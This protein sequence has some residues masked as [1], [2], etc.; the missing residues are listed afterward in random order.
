MPALPSNFLTKVNSNRY[1]FQKK[2]ID[3][4]TLPK[5]LALEIIASSFLKTEELTR[6]FYSLYNELLYLFNYLSYQVK[7]SPFEIS[8]AKLQDYFKFLYFNPFLWKEKKIN[9]IID[10]WNLLEKI[11]L[12]QNILYLPKVDQKE[13]TTL[14]SD[15]LILKKALHSLGWEELLFTSSQIR[16]T[17][18]SPV[19]ENKEQKKDV[20]LK[21]S[22]S[23]D[24]EKNKEVVLT[25]Q[26]TSAFEKENSNKNQSEAEKG[27]KN[28][29]KEVVERWK[30]KKL[31]ELGIHTRFSTLD[32]ASSPTEYIKSAQEKGYSTL[33]ITDHYNVQAFPEFWQYRKPELKLV[34]GCEM[35]MLED[36]LPP[37]IFN[38][39]SKS[40]EFLSQNIEDLTYCI[41]DLETTGF[42]SEYNEIIEI[43]Y[44]I[45]KKG[46][47]LKEK[48]YLVCPE[49]EIAPEVLRSWYTSIDPKKLKKEKKI[50]QILLEIRQDWKNCV[51]VAH[52][53]R[54]FDFTFVNKVWKEKF[55]EDLPYPVIDTLPLTWIMLPER[56]SYSLEKLSR[57]SGK[58]KIEQ[59]HRALEDSKL[60]TDLFVKLLKSL[61]EKEIKQWKEV[62]SL[63]NHQYFPNR[64]YKVKVLARNQKGLNDLYQLITL[65]H[66]DNLFKVPCVFRSD[67]EKH[68]QSLLIGAAG[69]REGEI[70][71][72]FSAFNSEQVRQNA[73]KFYD[74]IEVNSPSSLRHLWL[75]GRMKEIELKQTSSNIIK[76]AKSLNIPAVVSHNV[77]YCRPEQKIIK[78][79]IVANEGM[80]GSRH[81]LYNEATLDGKEDQ[82]SNL[83]D[84]HLRCR[85]EIVEDWKFLNNAK[86]MEEVIFTNPQKIVEQI[87][88]IVIFDGQL[89]YPDFSESEQK[90]V[91]VYQQKAQEM[92]GNDLPFLVRERINKEW[93]IICEN[94]LSIYWLAY[95]IVQKT[96]QDGFIVGSRGSVGSSFLAYLLN[97]TDLNPL[98]PYYFCQN[99]KYFELYQTNQKVF[100]CYDVD[101]F[102]VC[103]KCKNQLILEGHNLP[104]ETFFGWRGEKTP[105][106]DLNFS[107]EY[108]KT[109]HDYVRGLLGEENVYR[110]GTINKLS[111]QT[112]EIFLREYKKLK[113]SLNPKFNP[114][115]GNGED[116]K[117]WEQLKGI[118]RTT[119]QHPGGLLV[120]PQAI[121]IHDYTP[122]NFPADNKNIEWKTTH[123]EYSFLAKIFLKLDILGHDEPTVL[124]K[125]YELTKINP[126]EVSFHDK[127]I[128]EIFTYADTLGIPE[129]GTDFVKKNFLKPLK[130]TKFSQLVQ[131]S[132]FSHGT[133]VWTQNQ[134]GLYKEGMKL[135]ELIA[136]RE[137]IWTFLV[138]WGVDNKTAFLASEYIRKGKWDVLKPEIKKIIREKLGLTDK[139]IDD[140]A[141]NLKIKQENLTDVL[142]QELTKLDESALSVLLQKLGENLEKLPE[143][144]AKNEKKINYLLNIL[145]KTRQILEENE[146][147]PEV[148]KAFQKAEERISLFSPEKEK[149]PDETN[150]EIDQLEWLIRQRKEARETLEFLTKLIPVKSKPLL[151]E[152]QDLKKS[153]KELSS[154]EKY[155]NI[156]SKIQ[157]IF[158]K[159]HAIAYTTTAWRTAYYKVHHPQEFYS[160]LLTYHV[161]VHDIWLMTFDLESINF[162]ID[163]LLGTI[164]KA[165]N[166]E[167]ELLSIIKVL[168]ELIK[169]I[170]GQSKENKNEFLT[171]KKTEISNILQT[172]KQKILEQI[173]TESKEQ[174][175][176][177]KEINKA[178]LLSKIL[179]HL[180]LTDEE[181]KKVKSKVSVPSYSLREWKL[182]AK[183][184]E[185]LY[186]LKIILEM[187]QKN[188]DFQLGVDF[189]KS[190]TKNFQIS[191]GKILIPFSAITGIGEVIAKKLAD[192]RHQKGKIENWKEELVTVLNKNHLEQLEYLEKYHLIIN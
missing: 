15:I 37:Y 102:L 147:N 73:M 191:E 182:T 129:F 17:L 47:I 68:R 35:E 23:G 164:S 189:N 27:A 87:D 45:W 31:I 25:A 132:G 112:A 88:E 96:H 34:Y 175:E 70:F 99:C 145:K 135:E 192:C 186:T 29:S 56:K 188:L 30:E 6:I 76:T 24:S 5:S 51:L 114:H 32:G 113:K 136:C 149:L 144:E 104:F 141:K 117:L 52:N 106:I 85:E 61:S 110:I 40:R 74:Y 160:V 53:A 28:L 159:P 2:G 90:L 78:Q 7:F 118:K 79:I 122:L 157:Y 174:S 83:P 179:P 152:I 4:A 119:G 162:R 100:S 184:K 105:D 62:E 146:K 63:I 42:F 154:G 48:N 190:E 3:L 125:L 167:K 36:K 137:D 172:T 38:H 168:Q 150:K 127:K 111:Q 134:Q 166:S 178:L 41:F 71:S 60:L 18:S 158:P 128:M 80:N 180:N 13:L 43:G 153:V 91:Q 148:E 11:V 67:L 65:S 55:G 143:D 171:Q 185:L 16:K 22:A 84:Q 89:Q 8:K 77:H 130:P 64:G 156:L 93:K 10:Q 39:S 115:N 81:P 97:I 101:Q 72:L 138:S 163:N 33:G 108:Q 176:K 103:P 54:N 151:K 82:F 94:Y 49:K 9:L 50:K 121:D 12:R 58:G 92:F 170:N 1:D 165:K 155:Y 69:N 131:I 187:K 21:R 109:A 183:E 14:R 140:L 66:T 75:N 107:G 120:I 124:Q 26:K 86:L 173:I 181:R 95:Q 123:F 98:P 126:T 19:K 59:A 142:S 177:E 20:E 46:E 161:A 169:G 133:N 57:S 44:V 139:F 116:E